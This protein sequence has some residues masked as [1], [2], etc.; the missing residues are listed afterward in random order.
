MDARRP[1]GLIPL[2]SPQPFFHKIPL[3]FQKHDFADQE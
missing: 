3:A 1:S 2:H